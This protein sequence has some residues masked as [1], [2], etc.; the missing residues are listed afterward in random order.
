[1]TTSSEQKHSGLGIASFIISLIAGFL[2]FILF[3]VAGVMENT[4][5]G[6]I[7]E[8]SAGAMIIGLFLIL[9]IMVEAIALGLGIAGIVQKDRKS[10]FAILGTAFSAL[11]FV[12]SGLLMLVGSLM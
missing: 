10:V 8:E 2:L 11:A 6:G 12:G 3:A 7:D 5:P 9:L 1:M 4:S